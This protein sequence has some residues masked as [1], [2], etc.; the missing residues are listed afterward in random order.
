MSHTS[1]TRVVAAA[2]SA[3]LEDVD[4][5]DLLATLVRG[6][7]DVYPA[8]AVAVMVV[9]KR[10]ELEPLTST[11]HR[12]T[13][14]ELLQAQHAEGPCVDAIRTGEPVLVAGA[15]ELARRWGS[16]GE[17]I[18][19]AGYGSVHAFPLHWRG[20]PIGGLNVFLQA[21]SLPDE[22]AR[23]LGQLFADVATLAVVRPDLATDRVPARIHEAVTARAAVEQAKGVLAYQHGIDPGAAYDELVARAHRSGQSLTEAANDVLRSAQV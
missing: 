2:M 9:D 6:F 13:E 17:A 5:V 7:A 23:D 10:G 4:P 18:S 12:A 16:I 3:L 15:S 8:E 19:G 11:S 20:G 1:A 21:D 14:L 22:E